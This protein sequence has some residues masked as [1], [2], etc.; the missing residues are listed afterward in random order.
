[1]LWAV[2]PREAKK[3][4]LKFFFEE[5]INWQNANFFGGGGLLFAGACAILLS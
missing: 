2:N 5:K 4:T 1:M 3:A